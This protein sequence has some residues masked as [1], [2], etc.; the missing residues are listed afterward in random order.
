MAETDRFQLVVCIVPRHEMKQLR[1]SENTFHVHGPVADPPTQDEFEKQLEV[2]GFCAFERVWPDRTRYQLQLAKLIK[3]AD[4]KGIS[5]EE[6]GLDAA[7]EIQKHLKA[8][9]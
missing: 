8:R 4:A 3:D 9:Q 6:L 2:F 7:I 1:F 5:L